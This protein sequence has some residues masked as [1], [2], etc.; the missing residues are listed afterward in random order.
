MG[1]RQND[2]SACTHSNGAIAHRPASESECGKR[3]QQ[4]RARPTARPP[5][6][7]SRGRSSLL[8]CSTSLFSFASCVCV[9]FFYSL[10]SQI[11]GSRSGAKPA[12]AVDDH[13]TINYISYLYYELCCVVMLW[14]RIVAVVLPLSLSYTWQQHQVVVRPSGCSGTGKTACGM[15]HTP[16]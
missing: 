7:I 2:K 3:I 8:K 14:W 10:W 9:F 11:Y 15:E 4:T 13:L 5:R 16:V 1:A 12:A 6:H